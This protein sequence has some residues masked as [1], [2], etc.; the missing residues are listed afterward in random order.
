MTMRCGYWTGYSA[1]LAMDSWC[2]LQVFTPFRLL[3]GP[4]DQPRGEMKA[5]EGN[6]RVPS[7]STCCMESLDPLD[8]A[9]SVLPW[10]VSDEDRVPISEAPRSPTMSSGL[11]KPGRSTKDL[12]LHS[13]HPDSVS[14]RVR[15][16]VRQV[17]LILAFLRR[18]RLRVHYIFIFYEPQMMNANSS[19]FPNFPMELLPHF[20]T[21]S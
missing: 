13:K 9:W 3:P 6:R 18:L 11:H 12:N 5:I 19:N 20:R 17:E 4:R 2:R 15:T 16:R 21:Y 7:P 10:V 8:L 1:E 14:S